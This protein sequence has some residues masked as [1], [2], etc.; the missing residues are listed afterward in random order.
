[1]KNGSDHILAVRQIASNSIIKLK[2]NLPIDD[3]R[4]TVLYSQIVGIYNAQ[5]NVRLR[6]GT[7]DECNERY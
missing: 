1:M 4:F 2:L 5:E 3:F 7:D 6:R